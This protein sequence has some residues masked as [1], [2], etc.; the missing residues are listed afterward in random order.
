VNRTELVAALVAAGIRPDAYHLGS[1]E[2]NPILDSE[3]LIL[4]QTADG[5]N[6]FYSE[7]G[8]R[9]SERHFRNED[10]ACRHLLGALMQDPM[11]RA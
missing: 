2:P 8:L 7:R 5:W 9:S 6:V 4:E 10:A 1:V 3:R 11:T